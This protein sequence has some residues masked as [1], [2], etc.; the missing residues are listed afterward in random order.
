MQKQKKSQK[1]AFTIPRTS[2]SMTEWLLWCF[3]ESTPKQ[4]QSLVC[5]CNVNL[6]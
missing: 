5:M 4:N 6:L 3:K 2:Q 1:K